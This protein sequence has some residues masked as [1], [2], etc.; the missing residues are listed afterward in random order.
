MSESHQPHQHGRLTLRLACDS[1]RRTRLVGREQRFPLRTTVPLYLD[2]SDRGLAFIY[3]QNP[4]GGIFAGDRLDTRLAVGAGARVHLTTQ[5]ATKLYRMDDGQA[6]QQ[7]DFNLAERSY[8]EYLPDPVI[9]QRGSRLSQ[10]MNVELSPHATLIATEIVGPGRLARDE[11]F[12]YNRLAFD[13]GVFRDGEPLCVDASVLEPARRRPDRHGIFGMWN[14][15]AT[16]L[17]VSPEEASEDLGDR[18]NA[19]L[20]HTEEVTGAAGPLPHRAGVVARLLA[21]RAPA[22]RRELARA[23][24][25]A[26]QEIL[27]YPLPILRK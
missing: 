1:T 10:R 20:P 2:P 26:R 25:T 24:S 27:G 7:F 11:R 13:T 17:V 8:L 19:Q 9:P 15:L 5:S 16:L 3:V 22:I 6:R 18:L 12:R 21:H 23:V 14:Y 4:T